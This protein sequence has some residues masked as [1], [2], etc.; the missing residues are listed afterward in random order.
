MGDGEM[1]VLFNRRRGEIEVTNGRAGN[2]RD[3]EMIVGENEHGSL[4][5]NIGFDGH[6][7]L[8]E[9]FGERTHDIRDWKDISVSILRESLL[10][11]V[12]VEIL[13]HALV[14]IIMH[15]IHQ[16]L[17][18]RREEIRENLRE[19]FPLDFFALESKE[20]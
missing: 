14:H 16:R 9:I 10:L 7:E 18:E 3:L 17:V 8:R 15:L 12:Q 6:E 13:V 1:L 2:I 19:F 4:H 20:N 11:H 5:V